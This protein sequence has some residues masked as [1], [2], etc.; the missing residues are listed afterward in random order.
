VEKVGRGRRVDDLR[1]EGINQEKG[2][3][4]KIRGKSPSSRV[5]RQEIGKGRAVGL[6]RGRSGLANQKGSTGSFKMSWIARTKG[7]DA[8]GGGRSEGKKVEGFNCKGW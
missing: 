1:K 3:G 7:A 6:L 5:R 2:T 8:F 4:K